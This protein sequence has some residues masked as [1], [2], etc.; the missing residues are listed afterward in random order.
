MEQTNSFQNKEPLC[1]AIIRGEHDELMNEI[2]SKIH[3]YFLDN[4]DYNLNNREDVFRLCKDVRGL[5]FTTLSVYVME[6][7]EDCLDIEV[8]HSKQDVL[9]TKVNDFFETM[10]KIGQEDEYLNLIQWYILRPFSLRSF[11]KASW[12]NQPILFVDGKR[13]SK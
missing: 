7:F 5:F 3:S 11:L 8:K 6:I 9:M 10:K 13:K 1:E 2:L 4:F 12:D